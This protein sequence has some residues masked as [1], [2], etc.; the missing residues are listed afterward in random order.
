MKKKTI[1]KLCVV[2][3]ILLGVGYLLFEI[4]SEVKRVSDQQAKIEER[5]KEIRDLKNSSWSP[6]EKEYGIKLP[7]LEQCEN[8]SSGS[9][10]ALKEGCEE[11]FKYTP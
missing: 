6:F 11:V 2:S 7:T 4:G 5:N 9:T 1:V 3:I 10:S 8:L